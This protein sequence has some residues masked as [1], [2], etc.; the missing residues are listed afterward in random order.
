MLMVLVV[1]NVFLF[2]LK[3]HLLVKLWT[4]NLEFFTNNAFL[5]TNE[6]NVLYQIKLIVTIILHDLVHKFL[7]Y[8]YFA[9]YKPLNIGLTFWTL[10]SLC[11]DVVIA[12]IPLIATSWDRIRTRLNNTKKL[13]ILSLFFKLIIL[14]SYPLTVN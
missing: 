14:L 8:F 1:L 6:P 11:Q 13:I 12:I 4:R 3:W 2:G 9:R 5:Y 10:V 7:T